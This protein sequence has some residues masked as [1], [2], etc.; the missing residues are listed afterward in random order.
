MTRHARETVA[1]AG[2]TAIGEAALQALVTTDWSAVG[3]H[4]LLLAFLIGPQLFLGVLA[5]RR[6]THEA[7]S[8]ILFAVAVLGSV[9]GLGVLGLN[10]YLF[11]TDPEFR[12]GRNMSGLI[13]PLVQWGLSGAVW[14]LLAIQEMR[15]KRASRLAAPAEPS[16]PS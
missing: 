12:R 6:R 4:I 5:W 11:S 3:G 8:R 1:L 2:A 7:R 15:E 10:L 16:K 14:L 9:V 13:V